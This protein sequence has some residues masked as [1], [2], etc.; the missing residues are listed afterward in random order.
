MTTSGNHGKIRL[1]FGVRVS[2]KTARALAKA[3]ESMRR[4]AYDAGYQI[5]WVAPTNY[6]VTLKFLGWTQPEVIAA[7]QDR[8]RP[9]LEAVPSFEF[10]TK[11]AGAF[12]SVKH[13]RVIWAGV[14][15][16]SGHLVEIA[17]L[18]D[19]ELAELGFKTEKR[20]YHPHVTLGRVKRTDDVSRVL[21]KVTEQIFRKTS[22]DRVTLF[23]SVIKSSGYEYVER[24]SFDLLTP[25][26]G[27]KR[28]T[29]PLK[30]GPRT[31]S[32]TQEVGTGDTG[33][34]P[35]QPGET[36]A[37]TPTSEAVPEQPETRQNDPENAAERAA[38]DPV[39]GPDQQGV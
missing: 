36:G 2:V 25:A 11:G 5:R 18:L 33:S 3:A 31:E 28:Q 26:R 13:A 35:E 24:C 10:T 30:P 27:A 38:A 37:P 9:R 16:P 17:R 12:P 14:D 15:D 7:V 19:G 29:E 34:R 6:H 39:G 21:D 20:D 8:L 32:K 4:I 22:V 1:F 23:E